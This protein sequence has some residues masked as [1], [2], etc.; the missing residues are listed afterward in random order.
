MVVNSQKITLIAIYTY[1]KVFFRDKILLTMKKYT[2]V[3]VTKPVDEK[4]L[5]IE[6]WK[7]VLLHG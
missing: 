6:V 1:L 3:E 4:M 5:N 7:Q 2:L